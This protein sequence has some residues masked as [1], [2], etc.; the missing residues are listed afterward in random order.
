MSAEQ[1][2][3]LEKR[4][5]R[6]RTE[7][8]DS[9]GL[10]GRADESGNEGG[11]SEPADGRG[12]SRRRLVASIGAAGLSFWLGGALSS[13][14]SAGTGSVTGQVYGSGC[15]GDLEPVLLADLRS[16]PTPA[17]VM[18]YA[19]KDKGQEGIFY[20]DPLD[21]VSADNTGTVV[22]SAA[23]GARFKRLTEE[24][25]VNIR[26]FGAKGD[27]TTD[28]TQAIQAAINAVYA[29]GGGSVY[30]PAQGVFRFTSVNVKAKVALVGCGGTLKLKDNH[31]T[32]ASTAYYLIHNMNPAGG[33]YPDVTIDGIR[34]DGN[35]TGGNASY[36]VADGLTIGGEN[37]VVR[38]CTITNVP[39]SGIMFSGATNAVCTGN[40][41]DV[42]G[43][44]GIYVNDGDG[45]KHYE[46]IISHNR[47]TGFPFGGIALKRVCQRTIVAHNTIYDCGNGITLEQASTATDY[48]K[49]VTIT[50]NRIRYIGYNSATAAQ[51]GIILRCSDYSIVADNRIE[52]VK[53]RGILIEA[54]RYCSV[55]GNVIEMK[56]G[57]D[58]TYN[59]GIQ[60]APRDGSGCSFNSIRG[61]VIVAPL[62]HGIYM[63]SAS[64]ES[65]HNT[66][67]GNIVRSA[68]SI[69]LRLEAGCSFNLFS[70]NVLEGAYD[71]EYYAGASSNSFA[72]NR[73]V[74]GNVAGAPDQSNGVAYLEANGRRHSIGTA[75]PVAGAW[76]RGDIVYNTVPVS[77]G[78]A[79]W[80][81][82]AGGTPGT[83]SPFGAIV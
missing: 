62:R 24:Q 12:I 59:H 72:N 20:Y 83:W 10:T 58:P 76:K 65:K 19:V 31:C 22:V 21:T 30:V 11:M 13:A 5:A 74:S 7:A 37:A 78:Y 36:T 2:A 4:Q 63:S 32:S 50:S 42:G 81:C 29:A 16:L 3:G 9:A 17:G 6:E 64:T 26:W 41:L 48:S 43:D 44:L 69:A 45:T 51:V 82:T 40:R 68:G 67:T 53:R 77:G 34:L 70:D 75:A 8:G 57:A 60:L 28:D 56:A 46:N 23:G 33:C 66:I 80:I 15:C 71:L 79:G 35:R 73:L 1:D 38:N 25:G 47:I 27:G 39:D 18:F 14:Q 61:N 55:S 49:N 54:S 52:E